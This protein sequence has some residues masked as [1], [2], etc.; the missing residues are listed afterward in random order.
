M[1]V[2]S[3]KNDVLHSVQLQLL[4]ENTKEL[5]TYA[6]LDKCGPS[7]V[8]NITLLSSG[9]YSY[10]LSGDDVHKIPFVYF[11]H[12]TVRYKTG[13][14]YYTLNYTG[15]EDV[16]V[17][18]EKPIELTFQLSSDNPY[19]PTTFSINTMEIPDY[20]CY[21][22]PSEITLLP[23]QTATVKAVYLPGALNPDHE[24]GASYA[25]TATLIADNGCTILSASKNITITVCI[26]PLHA[27]LSNI[28]W[29]LYSTN[30]KQM[31]TR[32]G[33]FINLKGAPP[34]NNDVTG[35]LGFSGIASMYNILHNII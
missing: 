24:P 18:I 16:A 26:Q 6:D 4:D 29:Y 21:T 35:I 33:R 11:S 31:Y 9:N 2:S 7:W 19:G 30:L 14:E 12:K 20:S 8:G 27:C 13:W 22:E 15:E 3:S 23:G 25:Y 5:D 32:L 17:E 1:A 28:W 34:S 10:Q